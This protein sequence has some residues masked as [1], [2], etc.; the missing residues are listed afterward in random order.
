MHL[1]TYD[2]A[3]NPRR[4]GLFL[5]WKDIDIDTT[6]VDLMHL[7]QLDEAYQRVNPSG[8]VPAL[9]LDDGTLMTEVIAICDYLESL[10]PQKPLLGTTPL[11]RA[12]VLG[13]DHQIYM[14]AFSAVAEILR[15][16]N[17]NFADRALP[18]P[19]RV[20]QIPALVDRGRE[21]LRR[22][23]QTYDDVFS[24]RDF[25]VGDALTLAD[26]D[27]LVCS[28]FAGWVKESIPDSCGALLAWRDRVR[29]ITDAG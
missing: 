20:P 2:P 16:G 14:N 23:W 22:G 15:N 28:E 21:R 8:T 19:T 12:Q 6:Q 9:V 3:P 24:E 27:L 5:A 17:A 29:K 4:L 7:E 11:L 10:Y 1:Y 25:L 26:I 13:W 18:G